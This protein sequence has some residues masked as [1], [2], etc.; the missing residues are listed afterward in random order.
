MLEIKRFSIEPQDEFLFIASDGIWEFMSNLEVL[1][2]IKVYKPRGDLE[3]ACDRI[4][5]AALEKW[6]TEEEGGIDDIT[7]VLIFFNKASFR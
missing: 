7:F 4:M 3:G 2:I 1:K 5:S 6:R